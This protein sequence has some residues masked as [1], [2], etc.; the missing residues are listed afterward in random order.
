MENKKIFKGIILCIFIMLGI[1]IDKLL[2]NLD[3]FTFY[4][5]TGKTLIVL[6]ISL[7]I[8]LFIM[9]IFSLWKYEELN[10]DFKTIIKATFSEKFKKIF[11]FVISFVIFAFYYELNE[12]IFINTYSM[13]K[14]GINNEQ[15]I[16]LINFSVFFL[17]YQVLYYTVFS[18][19]YVKRVNKD[20]IE[21]SRE[22]ELNEFITEFDKLKNNSLKISKQ[23]RDIILNYNESVIFVTNYLEDLNNKRLIRENIS[24]NEYL[25]Y[26]NECLGSYLYK[27]YNIKFLLIQEEN[28]EEKL[29]HYYEL[30]KSEIL[31]ITSNLDLDSIYNEYF[32]KEKIFMKV[33]ILGT[34]SNIYI[35]IDTGSED[36]I[37]PFELAKLT[38]NLIDY[39]EKL[40]LL[41]YLSNER[42]INEGKGETD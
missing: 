14:F 19:Y 5:D 21:L 20:G 4:K 16:F 26:I 15:F 30:K 31:E 36:N 32:E 22:E 12:D 3:N 28:L 34:N 9:I 10:Y 37:Y 42:N 6:S 40:Y 38:R 18:N 35:I 1:A 41:F 11:F 2:L 8:I 39:F 23:Y 17:V 24:S 25:L 27:L 7:L 13:N 29:K 33:N